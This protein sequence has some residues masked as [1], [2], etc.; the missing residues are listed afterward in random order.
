[1]KL[2][3]KNIYFTFL[4]IFY[5]FC[6]FNGVGFYNDD[7]HFQI[8]EPVAYLL[9]INS[10][11]IE[12]IF[13]WEWKPNIR[14]RPWFQPYLYYYIIS[15]LKIISINDPFI[16]IIIIKLLSGLF[17]FLSTVYLFFSIKEY[18][19]IK[20]NNYHYLFIFSFWFYPFIHTRT[21]SE[22]LSIIFFTFAFSFLLNAFTKNKH[23]KSNIFIFMFSLL[24]G[25]S[26]VV[27]PQMI[28]TIFPIFLWVIFFQFNF[29]KIII[30]FIGCLLAIFFG[31]FIDYLHWGFYSNTY[32]QIFYIQI[33][34]GYMADF[35]KQP[36]WF[37]FYSLALEFTP[38]YGTIFFIAL[39]TFW[40]KNLRSVFTWLTLG[41]IF[42]FIIFDHKELR[43]IF[44]ILIFTPYFTIF[45]LEKINNQFIKN[46]L[47]TLCIIS[48]FIFLSI[49]SFFPINSKVDLYNYLNSKNNTINDLY[50]FE[51]NPYL[52]NEMQ[53]L[54]YTSNLPNIYEFNN[55][56]NYDNKWITSNNYKFIEELI[57]NNDCKI[58]YSTYPFEILKINPNWLRKKLNWFVIDCN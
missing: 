15:F 26:I 56:T 52:I 19:K 10:N 42:S 48:N 5:L 7:E 17:G 8:L 47:I 25:L 53:P 30:V 23:D 44:T 14:I 20:E 46:T 27:R 57:E 33:L 24:L 29:R 13:Y 16:W 49:V 37:Y 18:F 38:I 54:F 36:W 32:W 55:L 39:I 43:F 35:G 12:N 41:T 4:F 1:M 11:L 40:Y 58:A 22:S 45:F 9:G 6:S 50:Y 3:K 51:E 2:E 34:S 28:F 31:L 21:S